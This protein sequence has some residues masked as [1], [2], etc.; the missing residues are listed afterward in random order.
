MSPNSTSAE[1]P[2]EMTFENP[3]PLGTA[4]SMSAAQIAPDCEASAILPGGGLTLAKLALRRRLG[5]T[6]PM[7]LGPRKRIPCRCATRTTRSC[8]FWPRGPASP[9]P[10]EMRIA[11]GTPEAPQSSMMSG[12]VRAGV[13]MMARSTGLPIAETLL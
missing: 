9:N 11:A 2:A 10:A 6:T 8:S 12:T 3:M 5:R 13:T 4:Q 1:I 7:Q